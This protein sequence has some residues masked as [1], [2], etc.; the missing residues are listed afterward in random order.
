MADGVF[1]SQISGFTVT[2]NNFFRQITSTGGTTT[3]SGRTS[4]STVLNAIGT[5][6]PLMTVV[7]SKQGDLFSVTNATGGTYFAVNATDPVRISG[8][9]SGSSV[10]FLTVN[11]AGR[12]Q[13]THSIRQISM[14]ANLANAGDTG[15]INQTHVGIGYNG[16]IIGWYLTVFP[17][18]TV[19]VDVWK[20][21]NGV[22]IAG[23]TITG[24]AKPSTSNSRLGGSVTL[25]GWNTTVNDND[26]FMMNVDSNNSATY[27]N[28]QL[29]VAQS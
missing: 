7:D 10:N 1:Y 17:Q 9:T 22:P 27:I 26:F 5:T 2:T 13:I 4:G 29:I 24:S 14:V 11:P 20:V 23:N 19:V 21:S 15:T 18:A 6:G 12:L 28:L 8:L 3:F 16:T 25:T